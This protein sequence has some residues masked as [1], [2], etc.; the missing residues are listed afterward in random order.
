MKTAVFLKLF[1]AALVLCVSAPAQQPAPA[2]GNK[3]FQKDGLSFDYPAGWTL[4]DR[5]TE[6]AQDLNVAKPDGVALVRIIA[7]RDLL[8]S[9][10]HLRNVRENIT[11]P[12]V[13]AL[14]QRLGL[15]KAPSWSES[16]C[17][18]LGERFATGFRMT[19]RLDGQP[20]AAEIYTI[21]LG[22]RL[23]HLLHIRADKEEA[24]SAQAWK[25]VLDTL[26][27]EPPANP[28]PNAEKLDRMVM[29]GVLNGKAL[30]K[31]QPSYPPIA[32]SARAQGVVA[33]QIVVD[34]SG[35]VM[36]AQAV[37]GHPTLRGAAVDAAKDAK[38]TP[39]LLCGKP[40]KVTGIIT[41]NFVLQ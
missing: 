30:R 39:T 41:Y 22:Q 33:I 16:Q 27:V 34:E 3:R 7:H 10:A 2:S 25:T 26:K 4:V 8:Q 35:N 20:S 13:E 1:A 6:Q 40:V 14:A 5:S 17:I 37:S 24:A 32:K 11:T 29:G 9:A 38:F 23:V 12:F 19:G 28:P 21:V 15:E 31:P 18:A 36:S